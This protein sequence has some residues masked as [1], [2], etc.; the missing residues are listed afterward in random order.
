[1]AKENIIVMKSLLKINSSL[2]PVK[3]QHFSESGENIGVFV[4][5]TLEEFRPEP[6]V[7]LDVNV[8]SNCYGEGW[9]MTLDGP[10]ICNCDDGK[11]KSTIK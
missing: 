7:L 6:F 1:M 5:E 11:V 4:H 8:C 9:N 3:V 2:F 10:Q